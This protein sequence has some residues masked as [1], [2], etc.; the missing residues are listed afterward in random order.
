MSIRKEVIQMQI[1]EV[2]QCITKAKEYSQ[3]VYA[4][5]KKAGSPEELE[6]LLLEVI[7]EEQL[8]TLRSVAQ[9]G[10]YPISFDGMQ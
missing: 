3:I 4:L 7:P 6:K 8:Q 9:R 1:F 5:S 2:L 10:N